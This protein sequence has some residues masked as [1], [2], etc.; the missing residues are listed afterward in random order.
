V[1]ATWDIRIPIQG[2]GPQHNGILAN[3][4]AAILDGVP[5]IAPAPEGIYSLELAN[6]FLLSTL[7]NR[8]VQLPIDGLLFE[9]HLKK[10]AASSG[11]KTPRVVREATDDMASSFR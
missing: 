7:E 5:L 4:V 1:P 11:R 10:L 3:F 6:S 8:D 2:H 9:Q